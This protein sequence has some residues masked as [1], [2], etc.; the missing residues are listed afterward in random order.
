MT[1]HNSSAFIFFSILGIVCKAQT[2]EDIPSIKIG[3]Q[4]WMSKNLDTSNFANGDLIPEARTREE[5]NLAS[6]KHLPAWCYYN[7]DTAFGSTYGKLYNWYAV[8]DWRGLAPKGWHIPSDMEWKKLFDNLGGIRKAGSELKSTS[9]WSR[10]GNGKNSSG[11]TGLPAGDRD[12]SDSGYG[13][14]YFGFINIYAFWWT[15]TQNKDK[16]AL[17]YSIFQDGLIKR[18]I[19]QKGEGYSVRCV[20]DTEFKLKKP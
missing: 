9:L 1:I 10:H 7:N 16:S 11:F 14:G 5:W 2:Y 17:S 15:S 18:N 19:S 12:S 4:I 13:G 20:K 6:D 8:S 3:E